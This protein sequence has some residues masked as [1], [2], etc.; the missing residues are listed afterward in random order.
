MYKYLFKLLTLSFSG[1]FAL[2][3]GKGG[4]KTS[5]LKIARELKY[6]CSVTVNRIKHS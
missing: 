5:F 3:K 1:M 4:G 6:R 2:S